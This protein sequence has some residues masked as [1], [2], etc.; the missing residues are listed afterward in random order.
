MAKSKVKEE[1]QEVVEKKSLNVLDTVEKAIEK[2][3]GKGIIS[4]L[5]DHLDLKIDAISTGSLSLDAALGRGGFARGRVYEIF[6]ANS[7]GKSSL[8]LSVIMQALKKDLVVYY[9]D[10]EHALDP[11]LIRQMAENS[12]VPQ[13]K[14]DSIK[15][16]QAFTGDD[17]LAI[18]EEIM[19]TQ[20]VDIIVVDSVTALIP[21]AMADGEIGDNFIG[22]L[23]RLMSK[24]CVKLTP[25]VNRTNTLLIF[26]NQTRIDIAK[27][28]DKNV[29]TGGGALAFYATG[30]IKVKGG[31]TI[32][33]RIENDEG[34]II[35]HTCEFQVIKNKL[36]T[37]WKKANMDLIY[38]HGYSFVTE[39]VRLSIDF[40]LIEQSGAWFTYK[41]T[42]IQGLKNVV[43]YFKENVEEYESCRVE[44]AKLLGLPYAK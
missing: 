43:N 9:I 24:A 15:L 22:Q 27:Y 19:K 7:S 3:Y 6:G 20:A 42:K 25:L 21:Q 28:G 17:N 35:G 38:G 23:A 40:G 29:P 41:E 39:V 1:K 8:A 2:K 5:K 12:G 13:E 4:E 32:D 44:C 30:R 16:V 33:S 11:T 18:A 14:V 37:P 10:A 31:D 36:A 26:I 34:V